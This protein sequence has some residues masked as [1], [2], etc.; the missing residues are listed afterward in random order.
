MRVRLFGHAA[1]LAGVYALAVATAV[2]ASPIGYQQINL[3]SNVP[4]DAPNTDPNLRNPWGMSFGPTSPFWVSGQLAGV[5]T[6]YTAAGVPQSLVVT[7][8]GG[9]SPDAGPTGQA[10]VGGQG[11]TMKNNG[12]T[13]TFVFATLQGTIDAWNG[14]TTAAVQLS[15]T[16]A[17][18][19][20]LA[21]ANGL[22]YAA[23]NEGGGIHV[24]DTSFNPTTVSGNFVDPNL[25]AG[26][27][28]YNIQDI[29][30]Q[31]YVT[32][33][34]EGSTAGYIGIFDLNGNFIRQISDGH[35]ESP[36]GI[37]LAPMTFGQFGGDLLIGNEDEGTINAFNPLNG[38]FLGTLSDMNGN[39]I[40]NT[41]L[42]SLAF[43]APGSGFNPNALFFTAGIDDEEDGLFGEIVPAAEAV[44]EPT[45]FVLVLFGI[46]GLAAAKW[47]RRS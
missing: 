36:W 1:T 33:N 31:L 37:T 29:N 17:A 41:G 42:W 24:F 14:G 22:L 35:L 9:G 20:G 39:P 40:V 11:F 44:P 5:A 25:P 2:A 32:Y 43:R 19:T 7:I 21:V 30:G 10:F 15:T 13:A 3:T 18:Y 26:F 28:P 46:L 12:G 16:G 8:P 34:M 23:D 27:V 4:G 38:A 6:L 45:P 47:R